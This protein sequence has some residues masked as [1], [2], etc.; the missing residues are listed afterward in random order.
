MMQFKDIKNKNEYMRLEIGRFIKKHKLHAFKMNPHFP[1]NTVQIMRGAI[2]AE[3]AGV[4]A[5]YIDAVFHHMWEAPQKMDDAETIKAALEGSG[6]DGA[7]LLAAAQTQA[8]K[9]K[10][11]ANT[12][13]SVARGN[14]GSPTFFVGAEMFFGKDRLRDVEDEILAAKA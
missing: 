10:L 9:D 12:E 4:L 11:M 7:G 14:F 5:R 3:Q 13:S 1:V 2:A 6:M 8:V